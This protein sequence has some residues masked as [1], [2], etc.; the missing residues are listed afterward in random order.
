MVYDRL[1]SEA[2]LAL[3]PAGTMRI[4]VG[5]AAAD[6]HRSQDETN[7]LL[8]SLAKSGHQVA[9]LKG[10]D[11][12]VFGRGSEEAAHLAAHGI[13]F[14]VVPGITAASGCCARLGIP[15]THRGLAKGVRFVTGHCRDNG[16]LDLNWQSLAD[17]DTT[18]VL[19][20]ALANLEEI[21][22][23]LQAAGLSGQTPAAAIANGTMPS[24]QIVL[25]NLASLPG[26][27]EMLDLR[28]PVLIVVGRVVELATMV[29][30][31]EDF[32]RTVRHVGLG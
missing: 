22:R 32:K 11:P 24:Q 13:S 14:D 2:I 20:M 19:Y 6:H 31:L 18:L 5:K 16:A 7:A 9:R 26:R 8:V 1:I 3:V 4:Y 25:G 10:G 17:P 23:E 27:I 29:G 21:S 28:A 30:G 15:L 12:F